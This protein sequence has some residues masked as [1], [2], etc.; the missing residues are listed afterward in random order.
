MR[1]FDRLYVKVYATVVGT[2]LLALLVSVAIWWAGPEQAM[3]RKSFGMASGLATAALGDPDAAASVQTAAIRRLS[4]LLESDIAVYDRAGR[5]VGAAGAPLPPPADVDDDRPRA[6]AR[7]PV[8]KFQLRDGRLIVIRP[9]FQRHVRG[10]GFLAHL[11]A[12]GLV[13]A[14]GSFPVVRGLTRRLERLQQGVETLGAGNLGVRVKVEGRDEVAR[15]AESFNSAAA[16]IEQLVSANR[17]LLANAS[18]EL[19][20][21]L[22]RLRL[23]LERLGTDAD[24]HMRAALAGDIAELDALIDEILLTSRLGAMRTLES[25][26][27]VDLLALA[28]EEASRYDD[29]VVSGSAVMVRGDQRLLRR[30]I[31]N[32]L[33][34]AGKHGRPPIGVEVSRV[35]QQAVLKVTDAGEGVAPEDRERVFEP[36]YRRAKTAAGDAGAGLG[37]AIVRQIARLHGGDVSL[38]SGST[39][40][41]ALPGCGI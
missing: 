34:N 19:R 24:E 15:V 4:E 10:P 7:N 14:I 2:L 27:D 38:Q 22:T 30:I 29:V 18:H 23:G 35:G 37:L 41:V 16:R 33:D 17:M 12:V 11:A 1:V 25:V 21:P 9:P 26:E 36:F 20:T 39:F 3:A 8:W 6:G 28:A 31:R 5:L 13:L 32:L 40:A